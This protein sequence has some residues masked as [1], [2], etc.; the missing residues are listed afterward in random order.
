MNLKYHGMHF[1]HEDVVRMIADLQHM[2]VMG[3]SG[4]KR[5]VAK[6]ARDAVELKGVLSQYP[7]VRYQPLDDHYVLLKYLAAFNVNVLADLCSGEYSWRGIVIAGWLASLKPSRDYL[8]HLSSVSATAYPHNA[9]LIRLAMAE[10]TH[11]RWAEDADLQDLLVQL[12]T[13]LA[14]I[15]LPSFSLRPALSAADIGRLATDRDAAKDAYRAGGASAALLA[16]GQ[17]RLHG[18]ARNDL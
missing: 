7:R 3:V 14:P 17:T 10:A 16:P 2:R 11:E 4:A 9:W 12:R 1:D 13:C 5:H 15:P 8:D 18:Q 6:L